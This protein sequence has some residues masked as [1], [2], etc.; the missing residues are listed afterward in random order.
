MFVP[1]VD[2]NQVPLMPTTSWRAAIWMKSGKATG[3]W[4]KGVFCV[5]LNQEPSGNKKQE[6][7]AGIDPGSKREAYSVKS[8]SHTYLNV[9][10]ET[11]DWVKD[12][13][14][15]RREMRRAR[16]FRNTRYRE[17]RFIGLHCNMLA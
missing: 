5:R 8:A 9:L 15:R 7:V 16:R 2:K 10:S 1:V 17:A 14:E 12:N 11:P 6:I 3:F 13:V 4:K